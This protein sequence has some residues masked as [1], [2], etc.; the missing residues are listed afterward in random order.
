VIGLT[1]FMSFASALIKLSYNNAVLRVGV[2]VLAL[3]WCYRKTDIKVRHSDRDRSHRAFFYLVCY[4]V[5][6]AGTIFDFFCRASPLF[7]LYK[8]K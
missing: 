6:G 3:E 7:W 4:T 5:S 8:Y 2:L 1:D